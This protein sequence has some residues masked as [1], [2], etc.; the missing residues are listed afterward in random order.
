VVISELCECRPE[1]PTYKCII[2]LLLLLL[3]VVL[4]MVMTM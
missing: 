4:I 3:L 1:P 2:L